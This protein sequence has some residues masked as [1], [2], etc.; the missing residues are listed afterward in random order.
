MIITRIT[1]WVESLAYLPSREPFETPRAVEDVYFNSAD[2]TR[3][4]AWF[5][6]A[7]DADPN[8]PGP[9]ILHV[10]GNAGNVSSHESFSRFFTQHGFS[11]F[12]FDYRRYGRSDDR[13][14]LRRHALLQDTEAALK[15]LEARPDVDSTRIGVYA[16]SLG[17]AFALHAAVADP[18][19][20]AVATVSAFSSWAG[21]AN[22]VAPILGAI[23]MRPGLD[24]QVAAAK[25]GARPYL[26]IHGEAD[27]IVNPR[28][29]DILAKAARDAGVDV[30]VWT[31]PTGDHNN[32]IQ[33]SPAARQQLIDF[34]TRNL[35]ARH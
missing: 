23:L 1:G 25:L 34:F 24:P 11:V 29:A 9:A 17:G 10:H 21:V 3:L 30:T 8:H 32:M 22:D 19:V 18:T 33:T 28:H 16:V 5:I 7:T 2:G 14:P 20:R 35:G 31:D 4:H 26:I 15:T 6:P 13:G 27:E 12:L